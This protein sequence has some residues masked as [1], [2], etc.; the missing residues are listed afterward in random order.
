MRLVASLLAACSLL[1]L[2]KSWP[3]DRVFSH[4]KEG[5]RFTPNNSAPEFSS[6]PN[7]QFIHWFRGVVDKDEAGLLKKI[8]KNGSI[9]DHILTFDQLVDHIELPDSTSEPAAGGEVQRLFKHL[10]Y[11]LDPRCTTDKS[12]W[13]YRTYDGTCNWL[14]QDEWNEG[15]VGAAKQRDYNQHMFSD[16]ISKPREGPNARAV[17]NAFFKRKKALYYEH[18]PLLLGM[19]EVCNLQVHIPGSGS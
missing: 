14:K 17:S 8:F 5:L 16:G 10:D 3:Y 2:A 6:T 1:A 13:W 7:D 4:H 19:I 18:T 11:P 12:S 15:G 9:P